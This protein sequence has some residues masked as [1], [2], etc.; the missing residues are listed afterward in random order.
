[1]SFEL[2][3]HKWANF[4][5]PLPSE[6]QAPEFIIDDVISA[7]TV[8]L[9]GE[10]GLGKTSALVPLMAA[11]ADLTLC[12]PLKATIRRHVVYVSEDVEQVQRILK[13]MQT[14]GHLIDDE[15]EIEKRFKLV[16]A[17]RMKAQ[18]ITKLKP[19]LEDFWDNNDRIDGGNYCASPVLV[20]DTTNATID[21]DNI[22]DNSEVSKAVSTLREGLS[23]IN[24]I[25]VG[26]IAK[27]QRSDIKSI[28]FV[29]AGAWEGDTQQNLYLVSESDCRYLVLGKK[30]FETDVREY[31][32]HSRCAD[33]QGTNKLGETK[34]M[35]CYYSVPEPVSD[36][37]K[38]Q[39]KAEQKR[40]IADR[41]FLWVQ[42]EC[43]QLISEQPGVKVGEIKAR[44]SKRSDT[45]GAALES[46]LDSGQVR[47]EE[48]GKAKRYFLAD[49]SEGGFTD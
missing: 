11:I 39:R 13:A 8:V 20:L 23:P 24:V 21:L 34:E 32:L 27:S 2:S 26:H 36:T 48:M 40:E 14:N 10:R 5:S 17:A 7:G 42:N 9:A 46:L 35:R 22:S 29:G 19:H 47:L 6:L 31:L 44:I 16:P 33:M 28:S 12:F 30:R 41:D 38:A 49:S 45:V 37:L 4:L 1:M 18:E 43:L 15:A 25:L 3:P